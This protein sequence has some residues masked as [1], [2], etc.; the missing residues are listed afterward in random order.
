MLSIKGIHSYFSNADRLPELRALLEK[1]ASLS[2]DALGILEDIY[3]SSGRTDK[4]IEV[5]HQLVRLD[6]GDID[7]RVRLARLYAEAGNYEAAREQCKQITQMESGSSKVHSLLAELDAVV[8]VD[9]LREIAKGSELHYLVKLQE[10][11]LSA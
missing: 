4:A 8:E 3:R 1:Q 7:A 5:C 6:P 9:R 11:L 10:A 2:T